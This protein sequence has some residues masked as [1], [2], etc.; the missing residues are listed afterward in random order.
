LPGLEN[1]VI[2]QTTTPPYEPTYIP[3][4]NTP[5]PKPTGYYGCN[6][7]QPIGYGTKT[8]APGW[9]LY[10]SQCLT[11][12]PGGFWD[13]YQLPYTEVAPT[14][15]AT[16]TPTPNPQITPNWQLPAVSYNS[17]NVPETVHYQETVN[18]TSGYNGPFLYFSN[19][20]NNITYSVGLRYEGLIHFYPTST[21]QSRIVTIRITAYN[22]T[23]LFIRESNIPG[24]VVGNTYNI[25]ANGNI[26]ATFPD[27]YGKEELTVAYYFIG[28]LTMGSGNYTADL[29]IF[30]Y[31]NFTSV[32]TGYHAQ[33]VEWHNKGYVYP[34]TPTPT[35]DHPV[36]N[37]DEIVEDEPGGEEDK[38]DFDLPEIL[39]GDA[40]CLKIGGWNIHLDWLA[41]IFGDTF[42]G[43]FAN[44]QIDGINFCFAPITFGNITIFGMS[45]DLDFIAAAMAGI[46]L[47]RL[48]TRS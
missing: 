29:R 11:Q 21:N 6:G 16:L 35:P 34:A 37:C 45:I 31:K 17:N 46:L 18:F 38:K 5:T 4:F 8:P 40:T 24:L 47:I 28:D 44:W 15:G 13:D 32:N 43:E 41:D 20:Q 27:Y 42:P 30:T 19:P 10:C 48:L 7:E 33:E 3:I 23:T 39:V 36:S 1:R 2:A 25:A 9:L 26:Y 12:T 22:T 14:Q